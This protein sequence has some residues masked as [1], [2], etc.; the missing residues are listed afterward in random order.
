ME[1][2]IS[3]T[4]SL[5]VCLL[6]PRPSYFRTLSQRQPRGLG[7]SVCWDFSSQ[8]IVPRVCTIASPWWLVERWSETTL[9]CAGLKQENWEL[10]G[11]RTPTRAPQKCSQAPD[12]FSP[13]RRSPDITSHRQQLKDEVCAN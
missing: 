1:I 4:W 3:I 5:S 10:S 8:N 12:T 6:L 11:A 9:L 13:G 7:Y 2:K